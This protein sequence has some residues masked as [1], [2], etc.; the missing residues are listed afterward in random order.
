[1]EN[2]SF[3][4]NMNLSTRQVVFPSG[5]VLDVL[6]I[7][8]G[9]SGLYVSQELQRQHVDWSLLE[10]RPILGGRLVN[11]TH[12]HQIDMGGAWLWPRHQPHVRQFLADNKNFIQTFQ[13]QDDRS[14]TRVKGGAVQLIHALV[15]NSVVGE[16]INNHNSSSSSRIYLNTPVKHCRLE[17]APNNNYDGVPTTSTPPTAVNSYTTAQRKA[18]PAVVIVV[19]TTDGRIFHA[20]QVVVAVPPKLVA[21]HIT[22]HPP[23]SSSKQVAMAAASATWMAGVTKVSLVYP[24]V[25]WGTDQSN[26]NL[27]LQSGGGPAFQVYDGSTWDKSIAALTFFVHN[28]NNNNNNNNVRDTNAATTSSSTKTTTTTTAMDNNTPH[29][30]HAVLAKQ[31]AD[32]IAQ[33]WKHLG[34]PPEFS[35]QVHSYSSYHVQEWPLEPY[36][37]E[38]CNTNLNSNDD[39]QQQQRHPQPDADLSSTEWDGTL[40]F[41]ASE[42]DLHSPGVMEGALGS[43][44]RVVASMLLQSGGLS[45][46]RV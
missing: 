12:F 21:K 3:R 39:D 5:S 13:Q 25:F 42:T 2:P 22:F 41:C 28:N 15:K 27:S 35:Q 30:Q 40:H 20:A 34:L 24:R 32:Q 44:K 37:S 6:I 11:D 4:T 17:H 10:A 46:T 43:A 1:M 23:L 45:Q 19:E 14:A 9:L 29:H 18:P 7:G 36:I 38:Y 31:V 26:F 16:D 33:F 8:G